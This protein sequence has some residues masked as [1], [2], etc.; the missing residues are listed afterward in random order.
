MA[1]LKNKQNRVRT[2]AALMKFRGDSGSGGHQGLVPP[3]EAGDSAKYLAGDGTWK[4]FTSVD[5][6]ALI[7][8]QS[9]DTNPDRIADFTT[10]RDTSGSDG[11]KVAL[12]RLSGMVVLASGTLSNQA[13]LDIPLDTTGYSNFRNFKL[14]LNSLLPATDAANLFMRVSDDG[15]STFEAD[16]SDYAWVYNSTN[17]ASG[18][19][20][21]IAGDGADSEIEIFGTVD[22][23]EACNVEI[24]I[25][26][27]AANAKLWATWAGNFVSGAGTLVDVTGSGRSLVSAVTTDIRILFSSGNI[28][29]GFWTLIGII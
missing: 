22:N 3:P 18:P 20:L 27:P 15:G 17:L 26:N 25:Y 12:W 10:I 6:G 29:S 7:H 23:V 19:S 24:S 9:E 2:T 21:T 13:T 5:L 14:I 11:N 1:R 28:A 4:A 8:A 16:A